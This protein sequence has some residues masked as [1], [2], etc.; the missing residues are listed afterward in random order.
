MRGNYE[1]SIESLRGL[2]RNDP[3]NHRLYTEIAECYMLLGDKNKA[4]EILAEFQ[5]LGIRNSFVSNLLDKLR[6]GNR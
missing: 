1:N 2:L 4:I 5:K 3:K 6:S